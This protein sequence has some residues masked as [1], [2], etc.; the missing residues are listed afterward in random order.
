VG[1][2]WIVLAWYDLEGAEQC[3]VF[4]DRD[5]VI[6]VELEDWTVE[7]INRLRVSGVWPDH[8]MRE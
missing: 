3:Y 1:L 5:R 4:T 8:A 7:E 2:T 6:E